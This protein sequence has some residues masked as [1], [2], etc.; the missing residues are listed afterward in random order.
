[1]NRRRW[2][3][4][5]SPQN[6]TKVSQK[7][8]ALPGGKGVLCFNFRHILRFYLRVVHRAMRT[9]ERTRIALLLN[10]VLELSGLLF[11]NKLQLKIY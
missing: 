11:K 7:E 10:Q 1:M 3:H 4:S 5:L 9:T 8:T 6:Y 2:E